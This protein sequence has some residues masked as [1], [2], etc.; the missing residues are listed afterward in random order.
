MQAH[1]Q[2]IPGS[3]THIHIYT[4][5]KNKSCNIKRNSSAGEVVVRVVP[6]VADCAAAAPAAARPAAVAALVDSL[7]AA[8]RTPRAP[9]WRPSAHQKDLLSAVPPIPQFQRRRH[10]QRTPKQGLIPEKTLNHLR[11][12]GSVPCRNQSQQTPRPRRPRRYRRMGPSQ[13]LAIGLLAVGLGIERKDR[14]SRG[15][16]KTPRRLR[17]R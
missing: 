5:E 17:V 16:E 4:G 14:Y 1:S 2:K 13:Q 9:L 8:C 15:G 12:A 11:V 6:V 10:C 7:A 3:S